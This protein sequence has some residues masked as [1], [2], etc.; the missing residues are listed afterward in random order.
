MTRQDIEDWMKENN[1]DREWLGE[2]LG[3]S[4]RTVDNWF[5]DDKFPEPAIRHLKR[6]IA[7]SC[8]PERLRFTLEQWDTIENAR[9]TTGHTDRNE[10]IAHALISYAE[11]L[12]EKNA[13]PARKITYTPAEIASSRLNEPPDP[14]LK[15]KQ[16]A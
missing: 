10:F 2:T 15:G 13:T 16:P 5:T 9:R 6:I 11:S 1:W 3:Y 14:D 8:H 7:D 12:K 4:K